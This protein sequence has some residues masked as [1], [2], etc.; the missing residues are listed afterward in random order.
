MYVLKELPYV[1]S[2]AVAVA[3]VT[4]ANN[5]TN[6]NFIGANYVDRYVDK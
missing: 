5:V 6:D 4:K 3:G 2:L 1:T